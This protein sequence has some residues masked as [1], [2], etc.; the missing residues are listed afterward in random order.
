MKAKSLF[1]YNILYMLFMIFFIITTFI[2]E[3]KDNLFI[4]IIAICLMCLMISG[5]WILYFGKRKA[6]FV[7]IKIG[8]ILKY[9]GIIIGLVSLGFIVFMFQ[10]CANSVFNP[11]KG[12]AVKLNDRLE[13]LIPLA[14]IGIFCT[15]YFVFYLLMVKMEEK[16]NINKTSLFIFCA[17]QGVLIILLIVDTI[18]F[19][20]GSDVGLLGSIVPRS[21]NEATHMNY[22]ITGICGTVCEALYIAAQG[23]VIYM[24]LKKLKSKEVD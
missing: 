16:T 19:W 14:L 15:I 21:L 8:T 3:Q 12:E 20:T 24:L 6:G 9:I 1:I 17:L 11:N 22:F 5:T 23:L 18:L 10:D 13:V 7:I 2:N 4:Y